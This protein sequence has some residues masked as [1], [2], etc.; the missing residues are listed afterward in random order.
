MNKKIKICIVTVNYGIDEGLKKTCLSIDAQ[1][2][3]PFQHIVI[4]SNVTNEQ[5]SSLQVEFANAYRK[6][7]FNKDN[8]IY[9]AMN[10]GLNHVTGTHILFINGGDE[11]L[12]CSS[13]KTIENK[14]LHKQ[15]SIF[16]THQVFKNKA[17]L[18]T[19]KQNINMLKSKPAH[20]GFIAPLGKNN[21]YYNEKNIIAADRE[22]MLAN[23]KQYGACVYSDVVAKFYLGGISNYPTFY[24]IKIRFKT[25]GF[26]SGIFE[27]FKFLFCITFGAEIY[28]SFI[29]RKN[30]F[31]L[32]KK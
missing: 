7:I 24:T 8:S 30:K 27:I 16:C 2:Q 6:F 18:R 11:L 13:I 22:W 12:D 14:L 31:P 26:K 15:C 1:L 23:I 5:K 32:V 10:I 20:Q 4:I 9:N 28:Y 29:M 17:Y 21:I 3:K 25:S 19:A